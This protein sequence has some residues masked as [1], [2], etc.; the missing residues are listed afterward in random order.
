MRRGP[1]FLNDLAAHPA[2]TWAVGG[3]L[4]D[5]EF[6][7]QR[8]FALR[9]KG[10]RWVATPQ[11]M[12]IDSTLES[13]AIAGPA[14]VWAVGEDRTDPARPKPL[15]MHWN[16]S[17]WRVVPA[18]PVPTGSF[19]DITIAPDGTPW[20]TG[21]AD[22]NGSE[23][24]VVYRYAGRKWHPLTSGLEQS[25]NGNALTVIAPNDA[26]LGLNAGMAH[27]D[28]KSWK[29]VD[30]VPSDG[31][32]IPTALAAA[33]PKDIWAVG[34]HHRGGTTGELPMILH[35]NGTSWKRVPTPA[36]PAQ[37]HDVALRNNRPI[38]VG[39]RVETDGDII[40]AKPLV[41]RLR[42]SSFVDAGSPTTT[43]G[44]LTTVATAPTKLW[45]AGIT[46]TPNHY[47]PYAAYTK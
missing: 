32:H 1:A 25:I 44:V 36:G 7:E 20:M 41:L 39:E 4:V 30:D 45:T 40:K 10:G 35:Y 3:D 26:W 43:E 31:S 29:L 8:P 2:A 11:P 17:A 5:D 23:H 16:G 21:W 33:G 19:D 27:Y 34:V 18:P 9:W 14:D 22:V 38:A 37:L 12:R 28:G 47:T 15:V 13:V 42:G 46:I 24:A 6:Q